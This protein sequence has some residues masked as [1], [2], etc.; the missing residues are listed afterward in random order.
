M[1]HLDSTVEPFVLTRHPTTAH[2]AEAGA[3]LLLEE[4][5]AAKRLRHMVLP[6]NMD[7]PDRPTCMLP[8]LMAAVAT[9]SSSSSSPSLA[10]ELLLKVCQ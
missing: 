6:N 1:R 10:M 2:E 8:H 5:M 3:D 7:I 4:V 9:L